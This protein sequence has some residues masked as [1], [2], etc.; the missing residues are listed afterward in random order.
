MMNK[1]RRAA[2]GAA[3][4]QLSQ[5]YPGLVFNL[6]FEHAD[7]S[8]WWYSFELVTDHRR[9]SWCVRPADLRAESEV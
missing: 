4:R 3:W 8:G 1:G 2:D 7:T 9:Q 6:R 5:I